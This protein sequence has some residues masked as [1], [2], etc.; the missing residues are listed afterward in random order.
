MK[1][2][3]T[4][5]AMGV[6]AM[7]GVFLL[8]GGGLGAT[9]PLLILLACPLMMIFMMRGMG[10]MG[11]MGGMHGTRTGQARDDKD[12]PGTSNDSQRPDREP[13]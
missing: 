12:M 8:L 13:R 3:F 4:W 2:Q 11:G 5:F 1:S 9:L 7:A 6:A 10:G